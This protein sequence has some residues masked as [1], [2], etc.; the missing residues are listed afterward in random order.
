MAAS[1]KATVL[2][3]NGKEVVNSSRDEGE[4]R[5]AGDR[6][7]LTYGV[8]GP[9]LGAVTDAI[10]I[11]LTWNRWEQGAGEPHA[12]FVYQIPAEKSHYRAGTCCLPDGDGT[13]PFEETVGYHG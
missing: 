8:F 11:D 12:V 5:E 6:Y 4:K 3:R 2:Y 13:S 9:A 7:L 10:A 1:S